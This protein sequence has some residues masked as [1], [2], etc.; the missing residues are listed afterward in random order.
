LEVRIFPNGQL[1]SEPE[2]V[3]QLQRGALAMV[4]TS[5]GPMENFI[6][7]MAAFSTPYLFR[8]EEHYWNVLNG[9]VGKELLVSGAD[10]GIRGVCYLDA[11]ARSFYTIGR[12]ILTPEDANGL[13][14]RTLSSQ[15]A[16]DFMLALGA[17]PTPIPWGELYTALQQRMVDG[18]ENNP[19]SYLS[20]RHFEVAKEF[21]LS[22][23]TRIP[24][25]L[26]FSQ[27]IWESLTPQQHAWIDEAAEETVGFQ[28][29]L[30]AEKT[31]ES[32]RELEKAGVTIHRP[33]K[34]PFE[35]ATAAMRD[36]SQGT[37]VGKL[38]E[39]IRDTP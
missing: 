11:G 32:L 8:D 9:P 24:D 25:I 15:M 19:P 6:P 1:G 13:K 33:D 16:R 2:C 7:A 23:H 26:I 22:E 28:R 35:V 14:I 17:G 27:S 12:P 4:K 10:V 30:W 3:E 37:P 34:K 31:E 29:K 5:A 21:S 18:A 39:R 38:I 20:S 36:K